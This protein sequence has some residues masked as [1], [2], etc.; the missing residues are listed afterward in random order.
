MWLATIINTIKVWFPAVLNTGLC[1]DASGLEHW[2]RCWCDCW[3]NSLGV[4]R[5]QPSQS[6]KSAWS[7]EKKL[8]YW[9]SCEQPPKRKN[10]LIEKGDSFAGKGQRAEEGG[11]REDRWFNNIFH[12]NGHGRISDSGDV[13]RRPSTWLW[14]VHTKSKTDL[15]TE[16][17]HRNLS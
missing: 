1:L 3:R 10:Q 4:L 8:H 5:N 9:S 13:R 17:Q 6:Q 14:E 7:A 2:S 12:S 11:S 16:N 15:V